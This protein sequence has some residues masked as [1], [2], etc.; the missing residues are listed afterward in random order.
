MVSSVGSPVGGRSRAVRAISSRRGVLDAHPA[1]TAASRA[2]SSASLVAPGSSGRNRVAASTKAEAAFATCPRGELDRARQL[3][4]PALSTAGRA[5]PCWPRSAG[6]RLGRPSP[7]AGGPA[8]PTAA[9]QPAV[10]GR[11][12]AAPRVPG[13]RLRRRSHHGSRP[14]RLPPP[15]RPR[16][17]RRAW[18]RRLPDA[19]PVELRRAPDRRPRRGP[20]GP[21]AAGPRSRRSRP[22]TGRAGGRTAP[23]A[24]SATSPAA[25]AGTAADSGMPSAA[26]AR[27]R[28]SPGPGW[29][30]DASNSSVC[31]SGGRSRTR[32]TNRMSSW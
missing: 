32:R 29:S 21:A 26:A 9:A 11:A 7:R 17:L 23:P 19:M 12:S 13:T 16:P 25:S 1:N 18:R 20:G 5:G 2:E 10:P 24:R 4:W 15:A 27:H 22:R 6:R 14:G 3:G 8:L 30:A 28:R 31:V